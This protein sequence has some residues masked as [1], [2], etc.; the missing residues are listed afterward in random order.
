MIF[1]RPAGQR[2]GAE[3]GRE[4]DDDD[5][6][7]RTMNQ[8]VTRRLN[9]APIRI[10]IADDPFPSI[11]CSSPSRRHLPPS[12]CFSVKY[13]GFLLASPRLASPCHGAP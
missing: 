13:F 5:E 9:W 2:R 12:S 6:E 11:V 4:D 1:S 8:A 3:S 10:P 7:A